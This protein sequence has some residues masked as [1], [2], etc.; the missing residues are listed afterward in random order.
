MLRTVYVV[1][2]FQ[3]VVSGVVSV[4]S[5]HIA[6]DPHQPIWQTSANIWQRVVWGDLCTLRKIQWADSLVTEEK[7]HEYVCTVTTFP[8]RP[9]WLATLYANFSG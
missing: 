6:M 8:T 3:F 7:V 9:D 4:K 1:L 5:P 2:F